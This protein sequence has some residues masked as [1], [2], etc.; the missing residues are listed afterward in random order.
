MAWRPLHLSESASAQLPPLLLS[1]DLDSQS[2]TIQLTDLTHI[3]SESLSRREII[4]RSQ[5]EGTS[6]D[7]S[8]SSQLQIFLE[9]IRLGLEGGKDTT[10]ALTINTDDDRPALILNITVKLPGG[11]AP[12]KW[13]IRLSAAPDAVFTRQLVVPLMEA[14]HIRLQ[15]TLGLADALRGKDHIIQKL[16]DKLESQGTELGELF[17]QAAG[18]PGRKID[19]KKAKDRVRGLAQFDLGAWRQEA[20]VE[21]S[22]DVATL[23][24]Q[25]FQGHGDQVIKAGQGPDRLEQSWWEDQKG[26]TVDLKSG[27]ITTNFGKSREN[28]KT[29]LQASAQA[30]IAKPTRGNSMNKTSASKRNSSDSDGDFQVQSTPPH[31]KSKTGPVDT[32]MGPTSDSDPDDLNGPS[33]VSKILDSL[34]VS[35]PALQ[36]SPPLPPPKKAK[37]VGIL[38]GRKVARKAATSDESTDDDL[39]PPPKQ[40]KKL[41]S[42]GGKKG[43]SEP[44]CPKTADESSTEDD[45]DVAHPKS[46][47]ILDLGN[48][49]DVQSPRPQPNPELND[50]PVP[51]KP[52]KAP[53]PT[54]SDTESDDELP[55]PRKGNPAHQASPKPLL[56]PFAPAAKKKGKL[57]Q[58][59]G[60]K[61]GTVEESTPAPEE[62]VSTEKA[63][64]KKKKIGAIGRRSREFS[65]PV[66]PIKA[67][68]EEDDVMRGRKKAIKEKER[69]PEI[70]ET[71]EERADKK[72][73]ALK[74]ELEAKAKAAPVKKKRK[75]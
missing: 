67:D 18:K 60:K 68:E 34:P 20:G 64:P 19:R 52:Q 54:T 43:A 55:P 23:I 46:A 66:P 28:Q 12:L 72:R 41:G 56:Q 62:G 51:E 59:G 1:A 73:L 21:G 50:S 69:S 45:S 32:A 10:S 11:L 71:S 9:K 29:P 14:Q 25:V 37:K 13:P 63:T 7:P 61:K 17:P 65:S 3:W 44:T 15:E 26:I 75:F 42:V 48:N 39:P 57:G 53:A 30:D 40:S 74:R 24:S 36:L 38:G 47:G 5:E 31:L 8:D 27:K 6:I 2:Y 35:Q 70:R 49:A 4:R 58:V 22:R 33:Q 16:L